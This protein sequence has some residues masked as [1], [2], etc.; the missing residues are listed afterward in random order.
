MSGGETTN[1]QNPYMSSFHLYRFYI[2]YYNIIQMFLHTG[3]GA[4]VYVDIQGEGA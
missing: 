4:C 1:M 3:E 2:Y